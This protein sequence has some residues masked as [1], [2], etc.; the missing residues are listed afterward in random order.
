MFVHLF[1]QVLYQVPSDTPC[2]VPVAEMR[3]AVTLADDEPPQSPHSKV[4]SRC[5]E[6]ASQ[7]TAGGSSW[8]ETPLS[9]TVVRSRLSRRRRSARSESTIRVISEVSL[10][11][12]FVETP[13]LMTS[14]PYISSAKDYVNFLNISL[15]L[16]F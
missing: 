5:F 7:F 10:P 12:D 13:P 8:Q 14:S 9:T 2:D 3:A 16:F 6:E 4:F 1:T 15:Q 11:P